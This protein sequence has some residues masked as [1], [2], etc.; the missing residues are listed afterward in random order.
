MS[1]LIRLSD[2]TY[3]R[4]EAIRVKD[5]SKNGVVERLIRVFETIQA[6]PDTLGPGHYLTG[7][8]TRKEGG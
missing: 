5:E 1:K 6:I 8:D 4:L 2:E 7:R 3:T